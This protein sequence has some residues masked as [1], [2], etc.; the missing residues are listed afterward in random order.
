M[1]DLIEAFGLCVTALL[2]GCK[3]TAPAAEPAIASGRFS[4][5][6]GTAGRW[7]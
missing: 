7:V 1:A 4:V 6:V 3:G 5:V 2:W